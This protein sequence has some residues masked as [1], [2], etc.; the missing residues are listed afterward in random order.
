MLQDYLEKIKQNVLSELAE[1]NVAIALF[2]SAAIGT[3]T[4]ASDVDVAIIPRG[5]MNR[6]VLSRVR[7]RVEELTVPY[8]VDIVDFSLVSES[9]KENALSHAVWWRP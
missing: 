1:E 8:V 5:L 4:Y 2:G 9:F 6:A 3:E 7:E